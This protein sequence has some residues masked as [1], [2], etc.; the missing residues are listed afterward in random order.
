MEVA[1][2]AVDSIH[3]LSLSVVTGLVVALSSDS[4][5]VRELVGQGA[6]QA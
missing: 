4:I 5:V 3:D 2:S 6:R 1:L